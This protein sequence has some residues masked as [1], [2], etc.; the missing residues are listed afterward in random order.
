MIRSMIE[1]DVPKLAAIVALNYNRHCAEA[2]HHEA[3]CAFYNY[4]FKPRFIVAEDSSGWPLG[5]ACWNAD[6]CSWGVFNI[7]W[8]Q[9]APHIQGRG[10]GKA[11]VES[12]LSELRPI[13]SLILLAT[14]KPIYYQRWG[15]KVIQTYSATVEYEKAGEIESLMALPVS[16]QH[17]PEGEK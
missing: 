10:V 12:V 11:L 7:S 17:Q 13:A 4:P 14:T 5:C 8:V 2:F 3:R 15:F 9:V 1:D 6:W 16:L